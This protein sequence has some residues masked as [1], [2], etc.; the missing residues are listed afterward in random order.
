MAHSH[1]ARSARIGAHAVT[2][3]RGQVLREPIAVPANRAVSGFVLLDVTAGQKRNSSLAHELREL[4][5]IA[6][7]ALQ[8]A[9]R[10]MRW[11]RWRGAC[12][13]ERAQCHAPARRSSPCRAAR[14]PAARIAVRAA[15]GLMRHAAWLR[16]A[17][18]R[19]I[20]TSATSSASGGIAASRSSEVETAPKRRSA[21]RYRSHTGR[22][23]AG[24]A[25]RSG[26]FRGPGARRGESAARAQ[27]GIAAR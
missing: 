27:A 11:H 6:L 1:L 13:R 5:K 3:V 18:E 2:C 24:R 4:G 19:A 22:T 16:R 8:S 25:C 14:S 20:S 15:C 21:C 26:A 12:P 9:A 23:R 17:S 10:D 7:P